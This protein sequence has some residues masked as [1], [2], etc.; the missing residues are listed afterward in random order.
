MSLDNSTNNLATGSWHPTPFSWRPP[1]R[2]SIPREVEARGEVGRFEQSQIDRLQQQVPLHCTELHSALPC[3]ALLC[4]ALNFNKS[5][6][7]TLCTSAPNTMTLHTIADCIPA[8]NLRQ[9]RL[10]KREQR[11]LEQVM[12]CTVLDSTCWL[13][14]KWQWWSWHIL[15]FKEPGRSLCHRW[16]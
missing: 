14:G 11:D 15:P 8:A 16:N 2:W 4:S 9:V 12:D 5:Y 6:K 13:D 7:P 10:L 1:E 3:F